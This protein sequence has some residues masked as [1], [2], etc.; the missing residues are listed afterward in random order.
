MLV[1]FAKWGNS[2]GIRIPS[3]FAEEIGA[4]ENGTADLSVDGGK[5][6]LAP[7][8]TLPSFDLDELIAKI[9][10]ANRHDEVHTGPAQGAEFD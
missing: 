2:L 6:I 9:T 4:T 1:K 7:I 5:L 8:D 3:A 10:D